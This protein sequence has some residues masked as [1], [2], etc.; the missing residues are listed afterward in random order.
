MRRILLRI[1][2]ALLRW[3]RRSLAGMRAG[4]YE[5]DPDLIA[6]WR[7]LTDLLREKNGYYHETVRRLFIAEDVEGVP[8]SLWDVSDGST[9]RWLWH[10]ALRGRVA[11]GPARHPLVLD[12]GANDGCVGSMSLNLIQLGWSAVLVE[13]LDEMM[14]LARRNVAEHRRE[15]QDVL[16][17]AFALG[18][19]DGESLFEAEVAQD[20]VRM[21]GHLTTTPSSTTRPVRVVSVESFLAME[22]VRALLDASDLVLLS[23]DIEG[24]E[25]AVMR[26]FLE[27]GIHPDFVVIEH[28]RTDE[29]HDVLLAAHGY[30]K[31]G[32]VAFNDLY[33]RER[34]A[35]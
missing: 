1:L 26:G 4:G 34:T 2:A 28:L 27:R 14:A 29:E 12:L 5:D 20:V 22:E 19:R 17:C 10:R 8:C 16:F 31:L 15:G 21:E 6:V 3:L 35:A 30:R 7:P 9:V 24:G 13:P 18:D 25:L 11:A 32:R 23:L 33:E